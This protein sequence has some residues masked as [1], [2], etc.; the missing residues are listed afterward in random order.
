MSDLEIT[1]ELIR[2][3]V[4]ESMAP[5]VR[6]Q[7]LKSKLSVTSPEAAELLGVSEGTLKNMRSRREG[8]AFSKFGTKVLYQVKDL[9]KYLEAT[10]QKTNVC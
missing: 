1:T 9:E 10:G 4:A 5:V 6:L 7:Q 8:P 2:E 3:A